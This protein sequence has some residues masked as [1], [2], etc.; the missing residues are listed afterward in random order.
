VNREEAFRAEV[1]ANLPRNFTAHVLHGVLGQT[2][3]RII[4]APTFIPVY[5][6]ELSGSNWM[7]GLARGL[8]ALGM[9]LTPIFAASRVEHR[10]RVLRP[11]L[12]TGSMMRVQVLGIAL[13]GFFLPPEWVAPA[14]CVLL[15]LFGL[16]NGIQGVLFNVLVA[17]VI[18]I[19]RR[20][21]LSGLRAAASGVT[22]SAVAVAGGWLLQV[23]AFGNG[24]AALFALSFLLTMGGLTVLGAV[25][26]PDAPQVRARTRMSQRVRELPAL[27]RSDRAYTWYFV[28]RALGVAGRMAMPFYAVYATTQLELSKSALG[29]LTAA[30]TLGQT[31]LQLAWGVAADRR[32]FRSTFLGSLAVWIAALVLLLVAPDLPT[33]VVAFVL[34]GAGL[35]GFLLSSQ[36]L[37]LEFGAREDLPMR[38]AV[39]NT[40]SELTGAVT[41]LV[42]G[43][44]ADT[45]SYGLVF[46]LAIACKAAA[47][48]I[49]WLRVDE[50]RRRRVAPSP[51]S[52]S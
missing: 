15:G 11:T 7:V 12:L 23:N 27:L 18:P 41:P 20:G 13:A 31:G 48:A 17:K 26:E 50:P 47:F 39:S 44:L 43:L 45:A 33:L 22:S 51:G 28:A 32:G 9:S 46:A 3:F 49:V 10:R 30:F 35:G 38:V 6:F 16:F 29:W 42:A 25:R 52:G 21:V 40:A 14:I 1:R 19:E 2:G 24:W 4:E 34:L 8:Q 37:V 36:S 5:L